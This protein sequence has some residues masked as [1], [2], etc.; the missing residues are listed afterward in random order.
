VRAAELGIDII[1]QGIPDKLM[2]VRQIMTELALVASQVC[3]L[4]DDLP[5]LP[6]VRTVGLGVAVA[7]GC[8]ELR[9]AAHYVT[10]TP[11]GHGA[12]RETVRV[13]A[14]GPGPLGRRD[15]G[16]SLGQAETVP[17]LVAGGTT[18]GAVNRRCLDMG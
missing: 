16:L 2:S 9:A 17:I 6:V 8:A 13:G 15:P 11:G 10:T 14:Q 1:R 12:L 4:G 5:D 7:D 3:Y 18:M